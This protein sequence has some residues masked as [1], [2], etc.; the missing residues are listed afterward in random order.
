MDAGGNSIKMVTHIVLWNLKE[1][2]SNEEKIKAAGEIKKRLEAVRNMVEGI[3]SLEVVIHSLASSNKEIALISK[4]ETEEALNAYQTHPAHKEAG[5][6]IGTVTCGR[7]CFD[8]R[9]G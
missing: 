8:Y 7:S 6:Y 2:L 5:A 9:E 4:F 1:E 3:V